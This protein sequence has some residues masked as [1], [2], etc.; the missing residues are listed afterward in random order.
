MHIPFLT[1]AASSLTCMKPPANSYRSLVVFSLFCASSRCR[2]S[3]DMTAPEIMVVMRKKSRGM[4]SEL[5]EMT[6]VYVGVVKKK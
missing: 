1:M 2:R 4:R 6:K 3:S 5:W